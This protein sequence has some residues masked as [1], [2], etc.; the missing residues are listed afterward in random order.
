MIMDAT[1]P[2]PPADF[3]TRVQVPTAVVDAV[4]L[5]RLL[6]PYQG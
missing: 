1:K 3:P 6:Q 4:D 2:L 5:E